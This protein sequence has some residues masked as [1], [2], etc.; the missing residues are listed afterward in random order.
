MKILLAIIPAFLWGINPLILSKIGGSSFQKLVGTS[1]GVMLVSIIVF[2]L[3]GITMSNKAFFVSF[4]SGAAWVIGQYGQYVSFK[5]MGISRTMPIST[6]VQLVGTGIIGGFLLNEWFSIQTQIIGMLSIGTLIYGAV[7]VS[8]SSIDASKFDLSATAFLIV[9]SVGYWVYSCV[10]KLLQVNESSLFFAQA[11]GIF[12]MGLII[13]LV[14]APKEILKK[15]SVENIIP[16]I[17]YGMAAI[18]YIIAAK[19][20]GVTE[21]Y[22][23]GQSNVVISTVGG[24]IFLKEFSDYQELKIKIIGL[25]II[26]IGS[27]LAVIA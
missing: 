15:K 20:N 5:K 22:L 27:V 21:V 11:S 24:L 16:G 26:V 14:V 8:H 19:S 13:S 23:L 17:F 7:V 3:Y 2:K 9:T 18:V 10:P 25:A 12:A 4:I 6:A 1:I